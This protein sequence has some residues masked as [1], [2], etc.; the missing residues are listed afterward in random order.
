MRR[1]VGGTDPGRVAVARTGDG[2]SWLT[3]RLLRGLDWAARVAAKR[4]A[5]A[6]A[7]A[8][9]RDLPGLDVLVPEL[10]PGSV[11]LGL[12]VRV[13][14]ARALWRALQ[15]LGI[16]AA[17]WPGD[18][19]LPDL[20]RDRFPGSLDWMARGLLLPAHEDLSEEQIEA[21]VRALRS[22]LG[23][24]RRVAPARREL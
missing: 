17:P 3:L 15:G 20:A 9:L 19:G 12:P 16:A 5:Y 23:P 11:P 8:R 14:D 6:L 13:D 1:S 2:P 10:P 4:R 21:M 18:E 24:P 22:A 7:A